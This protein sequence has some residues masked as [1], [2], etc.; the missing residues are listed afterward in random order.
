MSKVPTFKP[1][2]GKIVVEVIG[3]KE[4][5]GSGILFAPPTLHNPRTTGRVIAV[6]EPF[7][8][9][10]DSQESEPFV[11]VG[12]IVLFGKFSGTEI[13]LDRKKWIVLKEADI[14]TKLEFPDEDT[15]Q[16]IEAQ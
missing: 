9:G 14:L 6:Y 8:F 1:M 10:S 4:K 12:D 7:T 15:L 11:Q 3:D 2:P 16:K 5:L 13:E